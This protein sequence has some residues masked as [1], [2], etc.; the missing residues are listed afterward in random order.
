M[1]HSDTLQSLP[2]IYQGKVRDLYAI[3]KTTMLMVA[4]DRLSAFDVVL[5]DPIPHKGRILTTMSCFWFEQLAHLVP[6]HL[7]GIDPKTVVDKVEWPKIEGRAL[8]VKRLK[9]VPIEAIVRGYLVGSGFKDY[10]KTGQLCGITLPKGLEDAAQLSQPIFTPSTKAAVGDHDINISFAEYSALLGV[11][12]A[13]HLKNTAIQLYQYAANYALTKG[14][15]IADT[16]FEFGL[17]ENG[18]L[19]LMDEALTPDSSRFWPK[20]QYQAGT[21]PPSF[22]KQFIR[23][24]L[25]STTWDKT[26]P[27]PSIPKEVLIKT[28]EK[29]EE[30]LRLLVEA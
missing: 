19:T 28:M 29:Y 20:D 4:S 6:N 1:I 23:D 7:T 25:E 30:A 11:D 13:N 10:Q 8:V 17:D 21:N 24:W 16:K 3:D 5:N 15:I 2:L 26:P 14:I 12:L 9:P 27:A 18:V 22:D